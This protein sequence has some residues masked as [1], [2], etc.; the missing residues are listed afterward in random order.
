MWVLEF[1]L[2]EQAPE[3]GKLSAV[4]H[5]FTA[6]MDEDLPL[7]ERDPLRVRAKAYDL[8]LNGVELGGGSIRIHRQDLQE[9]VFALLGVS[10][11][12]ARERFG[13]LL[14]AFRYGAPPHGGIAFGLD[15]FAMMLA[16]Q[17]SIREVIAFPKTQSA[18]DLMTGAPAEVDPEALE[19]VHVQIRRPRSQMSPESGKGVP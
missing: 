1:P 12:R 16:H 14:D 9:R 11:S 8:V 15:R 5:P 13:F 17:E 10:P 7:L 19:Q 6:P 18:S 4:H 2:L 3:E